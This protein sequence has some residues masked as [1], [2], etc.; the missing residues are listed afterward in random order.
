MWFPSANEDLMDKPEPRKN[1]SH[2]F[3]KPRFGWMYLL[4]VVWPSNL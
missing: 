1:I 4:C 2:F 3:L